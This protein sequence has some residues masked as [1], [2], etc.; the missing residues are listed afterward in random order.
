[1]EGKKWLM[2]GMSRVRERA[3]EREAVMEMWKRSVV[4]RRRYCKWSGAVK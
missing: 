4:W 3:R 2:A 1:M